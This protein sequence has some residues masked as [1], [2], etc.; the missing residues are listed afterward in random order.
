MVASLSLPPST[1]T[2]TQLAAGQQKVIT[3][4]IDANEPGGAGGMEETERG[5]GGCV[6]VGRI[7]AEKDQLL[8]PHVEIGLMRATFT[9]LTSN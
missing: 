3:C 4:T 6:G 2:R 7:G 1:H 5:S 9:N 8:P